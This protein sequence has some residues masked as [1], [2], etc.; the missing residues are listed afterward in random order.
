[1]ETSGRGDIESCT[2]RVVDVALSSGHIGRGRD[3]V[4]WTHRV[5]DTALGLE[6]IG[7]G[8]DSVSWTHRVVDSALGRG[9]IGSWTQH[10]GSWTHRVVD[11][12]NHGHS[13]RP[14]TERVS[15]GHS[16]S[17]HSE[18]RCRWTERPVWTHSKAWDYTLLILHNGV[19]ASRKQRLVASYNASLVEPGERHPGTDPADVGER[20]TPAFALGQ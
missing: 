10:G 4:S 14:W 16:G 3:R 19:T 18:S 6:H 11:T 15:R 13:I 1:M 17:C 20:K 8:R 9:H 7:R 5:V 2:H 12:S